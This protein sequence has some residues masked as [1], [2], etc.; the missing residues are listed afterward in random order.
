[1]LTGEPL[2]LPVFQGSHT[3]GWG[4]AWQTCRRARDRPRAGDLTLFCSFHHKL[5]HN[6]SYDINPKLHQ[7]PFRCRFVNSNFLLLF[8]LL[9]FHLRSDHP[10][11]IEIDV[12]E[13]IW[14]P[15]AASDDWS[16]FIQS[17][18]D[19]RAFGQRLRA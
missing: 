3:I 16:E 8:I 19:I 17:L 12:V 18:Q 15:I 1:M 14:A 4:H 6:P 13:R 11:G 5:H 9:V 10:I 7:R 2:G